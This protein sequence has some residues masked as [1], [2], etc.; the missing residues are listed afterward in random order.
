MLRSKY[1]PPVAKPLYKGS[2]I[3]IALAALL[4]GA[5]IPLGIMQVGRD[6][7]VA[8]GPY[9]DGNLPASSGSSWDVVEAF[10]NLTFDDPIQMIEIPHLDRFLVAGKYGVVWWISNTDTTISVKHEV[11]DI[12]PKVFSA[13]DAGLLGIVTHP[14]FGKGLNKDYLYVWYRHLQLPQNGDFGYIRLV[15]YPLDPTTMVADTA[16]ELVM[17]NQFDRHE[18]HNGGG[19]FFDKEGFL[20][21]AVGDEGG[22]QDAYNNGQKIDEGLLSGLLRIDVDMDPSRSHSIKRQPRNPATPPA[23]WPDSYSQGYYIPNDN[24]FLSPDSSHLEEFFAIGLRSPHRATYDSV[25]GYIFIGDIGQ[26]LREEID[27][28]EKGSNLQWPYKEGNLTGFKPKPDS[29]IGIDTPP[30]MDYPRSMGTSV[31]GGLVYRGNKFPAL[32]GKYIF[33]DHTV[34]RIWAVDPL[35]KEMD[36]LAV[37]PEFGV[38]NKAGISSFSSDSKGELYVCKLYGDSQDGGKIYKLVQTATPSPAPALLSQTGAFSDLANMTPYDYVLT[39]DMNVPFW[40]DNAKKYRWLVVPNDG[41]HDSDEEKVHY[42]KYDAFDWPTGTVFI[43]HF[44]YQM[45]DQ[46][47]NDIK[48]LETRFMVKGMDGEYYSLTYKWRDDQTD[49]DLQSVGLLDTLSIQTNLGPREVHWYYPGENECSFCHNKVAGSVLGPKSAQLNGDAFYPLTGRSANQLKTLTHLGMLEN[50]PDTSMLNSLPKAIHGDEVEMPLETRVKS[51]LDANCAYCHRPNTSI[52]ANFD[53]RFRTPLGSM[54]LIMGELEDSEAS[55]SENK[56]VVPRKPEQSMLYRRLRAVHDEISMPPL[57]KNLMDSAGVALIEEWI[58]SLDA[59]QGIQDVYEGRIAFYDFNGHYRDLIGD[60]DGLPNNGASIINDP[61]RGQVLSTDGIDDFVSVDPKPQFYLGENNS[62]Y[63]VAFWV[64][65]RAGHTGQHRALIHKGKRRWHQTFSVWMDSDTDFLINNVSTINNSYDGGESSR[66]IG[67]NQWVHVTQVKDADKL[68]LYLDGEFD[69]LVN[70]ESETRPNDFTLYIGQLPTYGDG[71]D[72]AFDNLMIWDRALNEKEV[73]LLAKESVDNYNIAHWPLNTDGKEVVDNADAFLLNHPSFV[74]DAER[75]RVISLDG[76]DD[77]MMA[78]H[79]AQLELGREDKPFSLGFWIYLEEGPTGQQRL[80]MKK[81]NSSLE[82]TFSLKL[83]ENDNK[84]LFQITTNNGV[85]GAVSNAALGLNKWQHIGY[86]FDG[87]QVQLY[88]DGVFDASFVPTATVEANNGPIYFGDDPWSTPTRCKLDDIRIFNKAFDSTELGKS[89]MNTKPFAIGSE[90]YSGGSLDGTLSNLVINKHDIFTNNTQVPVEIALEGF[91]FHALS[92]TNPLTPFVA[93]ANGNN[94]EVLA[95][96]STREAG[97]YGIGKNRMAFNDGEEKIILLQPGESL[98]PG[99]IDAYPDGSGGGGNP[100]IPFEVSSN[101][102]SSWF[103][104]SSNA[105]G[106]AEIAEGS[107]VVEGSFTQTV[108]KNYKFA[109]EATMLGAQDIMVQTIEADK[110]PMAKVNDGSVQ[111][112]VNS[113]FGMPLEYR[114]ISGPATLEGPQV[115]LS[116]N[117]GM[118]SIEVSQ[119]GNSHLR[120]AAKEI[121]S[122]YVA[123]IGNNEGTG[124][125][126]TATYYNDLNKTNQAVSR[127]DSVIDFTWGSKAP[128]PSVNP[129][130][131]SV[132]WEGEIESPYSETVTFKTSTDDGVRLW[133]DGNLIIDSW[134]DQSV[135]SNFGTVNMTAWDRVP[136][137]MEYYQNQVYAEA[138]LYWSSDNAPEEVVPASFLYPMNSNLPIELVDFDVELMGKE[139]RLNWLSATEA[140]ASHYTIERSLDGMV[141]TNIA[142][143]D[144]L[145]SSKAPAYYQWIDEKPFYGVNYYRLKMVDVDG[146]FEYS[147]VR[148]VNLRGN[149]LWLYPNPV[150]VGENIEVSLAFR[151]SSKADIY[152]MDMSGRRIQEE[153]WTLDDGKISKSLNTSQLAPGSYLLVARSGD[154][155]Q[156]VKKFMVAR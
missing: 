42:Y 82:N 92:P 151:N 52:R 141:Y 34:R 109:V 7:P 124:S 110:V 144:A 4:M 31:I 129:L 145:G 86:S 55:E 9:L 15:R 17:I 107:N 156:M 105:A 20:Y 60:A 69:A 94:F 127:V 134:T 91:W 96:G 150:K 155:T 40:S 57:A 16:N 29:L 147:E 139:A 8:V 84:I 140:A 119:P 74:D 143:V 122:F 120:A 33:G 62:D 136:I 64:K 18:W 101:Q 75:G 61:Q 24:P 125:G 117:P 41:T 2:F 153:Q 131:F 49:A 108:A 102:D 48:K 58:M 73:S 37:V 103:S 128:D 88:I 118:V 39:Y 13:G 66:E 138:H 46:N 70:L 149:Q 79:K 95:V 5:A 12:T 123:P 65:L 47:P 121:I 132:V 113:T 43:K 77:F 10:P 14:D 106:S 71:A 98:Y 78:P 152:L 90:V 104:G 89:M 28:V 11:L 81:G 111:L 59:E 68:Y 115:N 135:S 130:T 32:Q 51:Y 116:G 27:I 44:E 99:F 30:F 21:I 112:L 25:D 114:L 54:D 87:S 148:S 19:M 76:N 100:V 97:D 36:Y 35:S 146:S 22:S 142:R 26:R 6:N 56:V 38:G 72:A 80:L 93:K 45:D 23:G 126:L 137:R 67:L 1:I 83:N 3:Y 133:V 63:S 50:A 154:G 85:E 53:A